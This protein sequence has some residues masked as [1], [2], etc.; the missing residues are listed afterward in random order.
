MAKVVK[1]RGKV[2]ILDPGA[3]EAR[4]LKKDARLK[5]DS[6]ILTGKAS[7]V[8][9]RFLDGSILNLGPD[10]KFVVVEFKQNKPGVVSLIKG[11]LRSKVIKEKEQSKNKLFIRTR[12][13]ALGVRGTDFQ[14]IYNPENKVTSLLTYQGEVAMVKMDDPSDGVKKKKLKNKYVRTRDGKIKVQKTEKIKVEGTK[15]LEK[16]L[17]KKDAVVVKQGQFSGTLQKLDTVSK[18]VKINPVQLNVLYKNTELEE[19]SEKKVKEVDI[20]P[21]ETKIALKPAEQE[22]PEEGV[23]DAKK[24]VFAPK[25]GGLLDLKTGLYVPPAD[26]AVFD[27]KNKVYVSKEIG[28]IDKT[29]GQ[30]VAPVGLKLDAKKG[31]VAKKLKPSAPLELK[32]KIALNQKKLN[33]SQSVDLFVGKK[34]KVVKKKSQVLSSRELLTKE[35]VSLAFY[36][37]DH[38]INVID[39]TFTGQYNRDFRST[40]GKEFRLIWDH[41]SGN[42]WQPTTMLGYREINFSS[43]QL[44]NGSIAQRGAAQII[45]SVGLRYSMSPRWSFLSRL[46]LDQE[47][48][49]NHN[50]STSGGAGNELI[51]VTLPKAQIGFEGD[52]F[53]SGSGKFRIETELALIAIAGKSSG[54][55]EVEN[56]LG[57]MGYLGAKYWW[58][59]RYFTKLGAH[60]VS[61]TYS[62]KNDNF[63]AELDRHRGGVLL[64]FG[65]TL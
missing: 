21:N 64:T 30:Y 27:T 6:S 38:E 62:V 52:L 12:T 7:F 36:G 8:R 49:L 57:F 1:I 65:A 18:P 31:F 53:R 28:K 10:S 35:T 54:S 19:T 4:R 14:T 40:D 47:L 50:S 39:D 3:H 59:T 60:I 11:K 5:E 17:Q 46:S 16:V 32:E 45:M 44:S 48:F 42:K 2:T 33:K 29:T 22:V 58:N 55:F 25:A 13:A 24:K 63:T 56:G 20:D 51:R 26:D 9:I 34:A 15:E 37:H 41:S 61:E 43:E 23:F